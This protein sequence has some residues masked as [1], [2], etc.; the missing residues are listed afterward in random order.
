MKKAK[1]YRL[2]EDVIALLDA[3]K[4]SDVPARSEVDIVSLAIKQLALEYV[5]VDEII[6]QQFY[7]SLAA[8]PAVNKKV[9]TRA[10]VED[11]MYKTF[12]D[13]EPGTKISI[14][15]TNGFFKKVYDNAVCYGIEGFDPAYTAT[16]GFDEIDSYKV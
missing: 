3:L 5:N 2:D 7:K 10:K 1:T 6:T 8:K 4:E 15:G 14:N 16:I 13:L 12:A 11:Q 9:V